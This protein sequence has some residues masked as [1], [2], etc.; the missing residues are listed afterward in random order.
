MNESTTIPPPPHS[1]A[2]MHAL[3]RAQPWLHRF[4]WANRLLL[5]MA[6]L[7]TGLV[8]ASGQRF[9]T[10]PV[11]D[12]VGFF[13]E[14]MYRTGPYWRFIGL[15][16]IA[17][18]LFLLIPATA[19]LGAILFLPVLVSIVLITW[20]VGF[21]GTVY[22]TSAM[23]LCVAYLLCWDSDRLWAAGWHVLGRRPGRSLL[24]DIDGTERWGWILGGCSG[25]GLFLVTRGF[26]PRETTVGLLSAGALAVVLLMVGWVRGSGRSRSAGPT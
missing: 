5:A 21:T 4:T 18:A 16:Q 20:G 14:A 6:F 15:C 9:T 22:V 1:L 12:P 25:M 17:A 24:A 23:L 2:R 8:K 11:E 10:L 13:F 19:T 7:P 3:A 26:L